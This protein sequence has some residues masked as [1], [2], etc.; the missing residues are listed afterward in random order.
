MLEV[1]GWTL[2]CLTLVYLYIYI[3][4]A[5]RRGRRPLQRLIYGL[6]TLQYYFVFPFLI[7]H[8]N[9]RHFYKCLFLLFYFYYSLNH[10][11]VCVCVCVYSIKAFNVSYHFNSPSFVFMAVID[12]L[13][14]LLFIRA[15]SAVPPTI[16]NTFSGRGIRLKMYYINLL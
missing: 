5:G 11:C 16:I 2:D 3:L 9:L 14:I 12:H 8:Q 4:F 6:R 15:R 7:A 13:Y 10:L 1:R